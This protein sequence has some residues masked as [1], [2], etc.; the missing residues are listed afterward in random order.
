MRGYDTM[1]YPN[2]IMNHLELSLNVAN[3]TIISTDMTMIVRGLN[4]F[5]DNAT[6]H[7]YDD[8]WWGV[9]TAIDNCCSFAHEYSI[10]ARK[11]M[12]TVAKV[13]IYCDN[14]RRNGN[15]INDSQNVR[16]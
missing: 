7:I 13:A 14:I 12:I 9:L 4:H 8:G 10:I 1:N 16:K 6:M 11:P 2:S 15:T 5:L 3:D